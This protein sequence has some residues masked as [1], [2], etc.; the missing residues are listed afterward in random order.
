VPVN[1]EH[2]C[3][4][5]IKISFRTLSRPR[6]PRSYPTLLQH[7]TG[8]R[9]CRNLLVN[10][11]T[12]VLCQTRIKVLNPYRTQ[13]RR[14]ATTNANPTQNLASLRQNYALALCRINQTLKHTVFITD[15]DVCIFSKDIFRTCTENPAYH[16]LEPLA[17]RVKNAVMMYTRDAELAKPTL[18]S[19][20]RFER[21]YGD[22]KDWK[23]V[24]RC[25]CMFCMQK[26]D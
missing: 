7:S 25:K 20:A 13:H 4:I 5:S 2:G 24:F 3:S 15:E 10:F 22:R 9:L 21:V 8:Y 11:H 1:V 18:D 17:R 14:M 6:T 26:I 23:E 16:H 12:F 19:I